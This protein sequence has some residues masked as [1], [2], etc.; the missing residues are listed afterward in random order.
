MNFRIRHVRSALMF[1]SA[2]SLASCVGSPSVPI[3]SSGATST[4]TRLQPL[5]RTGNRSNLNL[6][7]PKAISAQ[8][9]VSQHGT[10]GLK[11]SLDDYHAPN[12]KNKR[13]FCHI[14]SI[15]HSQ[16]TA[17]EVDASG[18]LW[19]PQGPEVTSYAPNCGKQGMTLSEPG[20]NADD[21]A[22]GARGI[23]YVS[24]ATESGGGNIAVYPAGATEPTRTLR[25]AAVSY[26]VGVGVDSHDNV[27]ESFINSSSNGG[28]VVEYQRGRM[29][30]KLL[31][32]VAVTLPG[33]PLFDRG[34]NL[35][36][37]DSASTTAT[38]NI[39]APPYNKPPISFAAKSLSYQCSLNYDEANLA[40]AD[41][42]LNT[43]DI[44]KYPNGSYLYS[45]NRGLRGVPSFTLGV[46]QFPRG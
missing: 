1:L 44:Y 26:S 41:D 6:V 8:I 33:P 22:F 21:I 20:G 19:V 30:G 3:V 5:S 9:Y 17:I 36:V 40:C 32:N 43:V 14:R 2:L 25:N 13:W 39:Y 11:S 16:N 12:K 4:Y 46:A 23:R 45:I 38:I 34:D 10:N 7:D 15:R 42:G 24:N 28:G 27:Y 29:P 31:E 18:E 37:T 35:I